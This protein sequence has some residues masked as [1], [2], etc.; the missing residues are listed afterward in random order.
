M[1]TVCRINRPH[2]NC[3]EKQ[4]AV[5]G[6]PVPRHGEAL[7]RRV[8]KRDV[9]QYSRAGARACASPQP[10]HPWTLT[11]VGAQD[12]RRATFDHAF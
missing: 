7:L 9:R 4:K 2:A 5:G 11:T 6:T 1:P 3:R 12:M 10:L 8:S